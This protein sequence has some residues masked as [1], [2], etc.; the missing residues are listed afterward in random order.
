MVSRV[1][2]IQFIDEFGDISVSLKN[3]M[4]VLM[5]AGDVSLRRGRVERWVLLP[6]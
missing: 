4:S 2:I 1:D 5:N 6:G 3:L